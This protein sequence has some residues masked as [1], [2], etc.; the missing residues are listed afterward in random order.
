MKWI[1]LVLVALLVS[2]T[3]RMW[4]GQSSFQKI[5]QQQEKVALIKAENRVLAQRNSKINA[6]IV[7]L[8][9][10]RDAIEERARFQLGMIKSGETFFRILE[11]RD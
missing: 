7:S 9:E 3:Y 8:R 6:E 11:T 10:G 4:F 1:G 5:Q 2:L